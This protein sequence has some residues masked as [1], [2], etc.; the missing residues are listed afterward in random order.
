MLLA[1]K[2]LQLYKNTRNWW[3]FFFFF[4]TNLNIHIYKWDKTM[5]F[6]Q[7]Q[8]QVSAQKKDIRYKMIKLLILWC[9]KAYH[10]KYIQ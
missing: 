5:T 10:E 2:V 4:F 7:V 1:F 9:L 3:Y 6:N 8:L